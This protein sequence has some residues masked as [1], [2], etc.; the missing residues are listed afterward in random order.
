MDLLSWLYGLFQA[1]LQGLSSIVDIGASTLVGF[2]S[3]L[4]QFA[5][6]MFAVALYTPVLIFTL[7]WDDASFVYGVF[8][9]TINGLLG[10]PDTF[11]TIL[12]VYLAAAH[13]PGIWTLLL[14]LLLVT[15]VVFA[16]FVWLLKLKKLLP[17]G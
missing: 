14:F 13:F 9:Q 10:I 6:S 15:N 1:G 4:L 11:I 17:G 2:F 16:A 7:L 12:T 8:A 3:G 5:L